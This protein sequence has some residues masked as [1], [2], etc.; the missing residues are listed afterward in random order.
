VEN[1]TFEELEGDDEGIT[2]PN[3]PNF[4]EGEIAERCWSAP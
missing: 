2:K 1:F 3:A 4:D